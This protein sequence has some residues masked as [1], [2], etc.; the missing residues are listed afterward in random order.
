[1]D[2]K[3]RLR[4]LLLPLALSSAILWGQSTDRPAHIVA[5]SRLVV[6]DTVVTDRKGN[7]VT[8]LARDDFEIYDNGVLQTVH[9]FDTPSD[10]PSIPTESQKDHNGNETWGGAPLTMIVVD[11]MDT[12][13]SE[14]A[15]ARNRVEKY[16]KTQPTLLTEP[17]CLL[18][19]DD[20]GIHA[21]TNFTRNRDQILT[22]VSNHPP[23]FSSK[24]E[25]GAALEQIA[26]DLAALQQA[27]LF[28]RGDS[29][30]KEI[31][32]VGRSFPSIDPTE[33]ES[34]ADRAF[35]K[36]ALVTTVDLLL[37]SRVSLYVVDPT[38]AVN[39][40][41]TDPDTGMIHG[42]DPI[43][44]LTGSSIVDPLSEGFD[45]NLFV[46]QTGGKYFKG[47]NDIDREV[48]DTVERG[49]GFYTLTYV[50]P[51]TE[52][53]IDYH[54]I[55]VRIKNPNL[56]AQTKEGYYAQTSA[57]AEATPPQSPKDQRKLQQQEDLQLGFDL[58]EASVT[59][60]RYTGLG[61]HVDSCTR[62]K[63]KVHSTCIVEVDTNSISFVR[64]DSG[65]EH[66]VI[67][68]VVSSLDA[69]GKMVDHSAEELTTVV[70]PRQ[71]N[72]IIQ[73]HLHL[74]LHTSIPRGTN[75]VRVVLRDSSGRIGTADV[76]SASLPAL[77]SSGGLKK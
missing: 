60:M 48:G 36:K 20:S 63:D 57:E 22:A 9:D 66:A 72:L 11:E 53:D 62:D 71:Q 34:S 5:R 25:R 61:L 43:A 44:P 21:V 56:M 41:S 49:V 50:P 52:S 15:Y 67:L 58:Y 28:S 32:W 38:E 45:M 23:A 69:K 35:L 17:T 10:H 51:A 18:W 6:L 16:L 54:K 2:S 7:L 42:D 12:P 4:K 13:F 31:I 65:D 55:T 76:D 59:N 77:I 27:A 3:Y 24:M 47:Y 14:M 26:S 75:H 64:D 40:T 70:P 30:K 29:G 39:T 19:L 8:N 37:A 46:Q 1:M 68:A 33:L 74:S 73:G